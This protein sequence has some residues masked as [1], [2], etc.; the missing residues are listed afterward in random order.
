MDAK[1]SLPFHMAKTDG[2]LSKLCVRAYARAYTEVLHFYFQSSAIP[3][4]GTEIRALLTLSDAQATSSLPRGWRTHMSSRGTHVSDKGT[5]IFA[6]L[7]KTDRCT[8]FYKREYRNFTR[9]GPFR[10]RLKRTKKYS[11]SK[12]FSQSQK[13]A[14]FTS[15]EGLKASRHLAI[16]LIFSSQSPIG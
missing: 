14:S 7:Q 3:S 10:H 6:H 16:S 8:D 13:K 11:G 4:F 15:A 2:D 1:V 12:V 9:H 5:R